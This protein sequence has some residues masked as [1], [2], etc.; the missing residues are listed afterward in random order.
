MTDT[1]NILRVDSSARHEGS[2]S[3][4]LADIYIDRLAEDRPVRVETRDVSAPLPVVS[5]EW[6]GANFTPADDRTADQKAILATSDRLV[7]ELQRNDIIVLSVPIYNF[8]IPASLKLWV[9]QVARAGLTFRYTENGPEGLLE[10]KRA[11]IL[12][13]SGGTE[14]SSEIDF[15]TPYLKHVLGFLGIHDVDIVAADQ[16]MASGPEKIEQTKEQVRALAA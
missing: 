10:G 3:R 12:V 7:E 16:L 11:V 15:A 2:V 6:I 13:A 4:E 5:G 9:D 1:I 14:V 8:N